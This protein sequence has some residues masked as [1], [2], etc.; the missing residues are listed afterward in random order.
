M[1]RII[2]KEEVEQVKEEQQWNEKQKLLNRG[3]IVELSSKQG[4]ERRYRIRGS[5][6]EVN[7]EAAK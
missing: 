4:K 1:P 2:S 6:V 3:G 5:T 7:I